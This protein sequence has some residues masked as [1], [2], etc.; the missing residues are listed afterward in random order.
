MNNKF[1][2]KKKA[3]PQIGTVETKLLALMITTSAYSDRQSPFSSNVFEKEPIYNVELSLN[4]IFL[5]YR[6]PH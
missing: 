6:W 5:S 4:L 3:L 1:E 2:E